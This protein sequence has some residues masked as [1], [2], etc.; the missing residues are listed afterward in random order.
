MK[1]Q[2]DGLALLVSGAGIKILL[3]PG[4]MGVLVVSF[5]G[6]TFCSVWLDLY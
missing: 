3:F 5:M 4:G 2:V 6:R 1:K